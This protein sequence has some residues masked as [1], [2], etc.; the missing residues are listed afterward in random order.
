MASVTFANLSFT[1]D[2]TAKA[3]TATTQ[4]AGLP[5][6]FTYKDS[7]NAPI[8]APLNIGSYTV[9]ATISD[10]NYQ[11]NSAS[12]LVIGEPAPAPAIASLDP[13]Q[14]T[15]GGNAFILNVNGANFVDGS[16]IRWNGVN[17]NTTFNGSNSL[18]A[19]ISKSLIASNGLASITVLNP[20]SAGGA[21][22][23]EEFLLLGE[24]APAPVITS[25]DPSQVK[26]GGSA[27]ILNVSG[28]NFVDG[29]VIRWNGIAQSTTFNSSNS[30]MT[31]ISK[32][33]IASTGLVSV[34]VLNPG[35]GV[36]LLSAEARLTIADTTTPAA[37]P[38][39][40]L[41]QS[42]NVIT[43][44][45]S[46]NGFTLQSSPILPATNWLDVAGS[47]ITNSLVVTNNADMQFFRL[48][49]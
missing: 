5:I 25:L 23:N 47:E 39:M 48:K 26:P 34:T 14:V 42:G 17:Q 28:A 22:S 11:G 1:Y 43:L 4:P 36:N 18:M 41:G 13:R 7:A 33:L 3:A 31:L 10:A 37:T 45:W 8:N 15:P 9:I 44:G 46:T 16:V 38:T 35:P 40:T 30:L 29:S 32:P 20:A 21:L 2:G 27:F 24:P 12:A 6:T 19:L 49:K